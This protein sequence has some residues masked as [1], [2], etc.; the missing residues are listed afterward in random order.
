[1]RRSTLFALSR[2]LSVL[3][4]SILISDF[5]RE[6]DDM[7]TWLIETSQHDNDDGVRH[8]ARLC[9]ISLR[10]VMGDPWNGAIA[11]SSGASTPFAITGGTITKPEIRFI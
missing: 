5:K 9:L 4:S 3:S 10:E 6:L 1:M 2:V 11:S 8:L 7:I